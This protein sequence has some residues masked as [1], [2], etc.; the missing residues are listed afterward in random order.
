MKVV[1]LFLFFVDTSCEAHGTY[2]AYE[3]T[4]M[5]ANT[6]CTVDVRLAS[7]KVESDSL[8]TSIPTGEVAAATTDTPLTVN[9]GKN[10]GL[11][12]KVGRQNKRRQLLAY[13]VLKMLN[14]TL[15]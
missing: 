15:L 10:H 7:V 1:L 8:M 14:A 4:K 3:A 5:T 6:F 11:A 13:D 2:G 9:L 12:V